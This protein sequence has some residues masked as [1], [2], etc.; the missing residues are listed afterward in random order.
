MS[1][2]TSKDG[3]PIAYECL[4]RGS[5]V[6]LVGGGATDRTENEPLAT[7]LAKYFRVYNYDRRGRGKSGDT[8]PYALE[9]EVED[10]E[11]LIALAGGP[12]HLFGASSG[13]ALVLEAAAHGIAVDKLAV[14]EV[15]YDTS[16]DA[17]RR[18]AEYEAKLQV[19]LAE[20]RRGDAFAEFMRLAGS[21]EAEISSARTLPVW[22]SLEALAHTL[23]YDA[24][25][26]RN[27][28]G[29]RFA[30]IL[31]PTLVLTGAAEPSSHDGN[32][33]GRA[34]TAIVASIP[35]AKRQVL[36]GQT[37]VADPKVLASVLRRFFDESTP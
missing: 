17:P 22:P 8:L 4:G 30:A 27:P 2:I 23:L 12:V 3:T 14:Y 11:A 20:G 7:E 31:R 28:P 21:S 10:I 32:F 6:V 33:F 25:C 16:H 24:A 34:A 37:H 36:K 1:Q 18:F 15:P 5:A 29:A 9:R 13:G 35:H 19:L 26:Y